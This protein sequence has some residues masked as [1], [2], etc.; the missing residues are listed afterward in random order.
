MHHYLC[1]FKKNIKFC[2]YLYKCFII[3]VQFS[4]EFWAVGRQHHTFFF[5]LDE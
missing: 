5:L 1:F 3:F 2:L 4:E